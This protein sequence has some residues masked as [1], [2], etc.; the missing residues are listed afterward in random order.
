MQRFFSA[1]HI[2]SPHTGIVPGGILVTD[3]QG[4]ITD[5]LDPESASSVP[6]QVQHFSGMLCPGFIN[7][8][9]HLELSHLRGQVTRHTGFVGFAK[10]LLPKRNQFT[11]EQ[12]QQ[13]IIDGE[14]E[15]YRNGI[16]GVG[17]IS[18]TA[19]SFL[20]KSKKRIAYHTF[21]EL[22]A[23]NP[24]AAQQ[25]MQGGLELLGKIHDH[26]ATIVPHAPYTV[27]EELLRLISEN[28]REG[29][30]LSIHNQE[31]AAENEFFE[32]GTGDMLELYRFLGIDISWFKAPGINAL[33]RTLPNMNPDDPLLLVH[34]TFTTAADIRFTNGIFPNLYW[35]FCPKA[36]LY[37]EN[38]LPDYE[39]FTDAGVR[40]TIGTDSLASNDTLSVLEE[41]KVIAAAVPYLEIET[42][43]HWATKNGADAL[44]M[45]AL[46]SFEKGKRP[47]II[48]LKNL[49]K[50]LRMSSAAEVVRVL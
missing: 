27:S 14:D 1:D 6:E 46:G 10:E 3:A 28:N 13:A 21:I 47:G 5:L 19:D 50:E 40:I 18:N 35:C 16:V 7:T 32:K 22:L 37:I 36:N 31:S 9:C 48:L 33:R 15:M 43:L 42:L 20:Q 49:G 17:D 39:I 12:I 25:V 8:H 34:N 44:D 2:F 4:T 23:L 45:P 26:P 38:R 24:A 29:K 30:M 41:L 11:T